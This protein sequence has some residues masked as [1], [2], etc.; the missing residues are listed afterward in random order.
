MGKKSKS[1]AEQLGTQTKKGQKRIS[2]EQE[3]QRKQLE[4][5]DEQLKASMKKRAQDLFSECKEKALA[6]AN[7][8]KSEVLVSLMR[9]ERESRPRWAA[10]LQDYIVKILS[11]K[12]SGLHVKVEYDEDKPFGSDPMFTYPVYSIDLRISWPQKASQ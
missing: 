1:L 4:A 3:A 2:D 11:S 7:E 12:D 8:G 10:Y 5:E 9:F 6:A